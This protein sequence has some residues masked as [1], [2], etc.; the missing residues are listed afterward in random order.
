MAT[1]ND[2]T[3]F[4]TTYSKVVVHR[5]ELNT[6]G[7]DDG[8][9]DYLVRQGTLYAV[10]GSDW[11]LV[12][13]VYLTTLTLNPDGSTT[14]TPVTDAFSLTRSTSDPVLTDILTETR[15]LIRDLVLFFVNTG[16]NDLP[17]SLVNLLEE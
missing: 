9:I 13:P 6:R 3:T 11:F 8:I 10:N 17:K 15:T 7:F 1:I 14:V 12:L 16:F 4:L 5:L 2:L